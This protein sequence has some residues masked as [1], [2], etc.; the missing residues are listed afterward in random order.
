MHVETA[1]ARCIENG[2][3]QDQPIGHDHSR[4]EIQ[5]RKRLL[6]RQFL[7]GFGRTHFDPPGLSEGMHGRGSQFLAP[8]SGTWR[9]RIDTDD[10]MSGCDQRIQ[11]MCG[12][13]RATHES[14]AKGFGHHAGNSLF[15]VILKATFRKWL[16]ALR[17]TY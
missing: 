16:S 5:R 13:I 6:L 11:H 4:I 2:L 1:K 15:G 10:L 8:A 12:D 17:P 14:K 9:L 7:Q 3:R